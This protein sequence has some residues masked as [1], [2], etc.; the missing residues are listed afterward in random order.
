VTRVQFALAF[1]VLAACQTRV[2]SLESEYR[3]VR[4]LV[5]GERYDL[6]L[7][8]AEA[9]LARAEQTGSDKDRWRFRLLKADILIGQRFS[10]KALDYVK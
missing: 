4:T 10:A 3:A 8:K 2:P 5:A 6:A 9:G 1:F 7:P